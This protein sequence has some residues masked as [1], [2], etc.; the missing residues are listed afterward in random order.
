[1]S[2]TID[3]AMHLTHTGVVAAKQRIA[4]PLTATYILYVLAAILLPPVASWGQREQQHRTVAEIFSL[5][6]RKIVIIAHRGCHEAAPAHGFG[7]EPENSLSALEHCVAMGID[8]METDVH[9]TADGYLVVMH[10]DTVDR[11]TSGRGKVEDMTL[12]DL[13]QLHLRQNL[14]GYAEGLTDQ[15]VPTLEQMLQAAKGRITLNLDVKG[16]IYAEVV[17]A[18]IRAGAVDYVVLKTRA[19][20]NSPKLSTI[21]PF[22]HVPF[23][24]ILDPRGSDIAAVAENQASGAKPVALELPHMKASELPNV[25]RVA[26]A[27]GIKLMINTLGDGFLADRPGDNDLSAGADEVWGWAYRNGV[28]VFQTDHVE[29]LLKFQKSQR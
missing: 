18:V 21:E 25:A 10:D 13:R 16:A 9:M 5:S 24:P 8:M 14:G 19:G 20:I 4:H 26:N 3:E 22:A 7:Y 1:L 11:T 15:R 12:S 23:I 6:N 27:H 28:S 17:N 29:A 2:E